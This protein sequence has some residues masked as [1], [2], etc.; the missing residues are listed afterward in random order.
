MAGR[1]CC[2]CCS[3]WYNVNV[4]KVK[5]KKLKKIPKSAGK[6]AKDRVEALLEDMSGSFEAFGEALVLTRESLSNDI[7][8]LGKEM[9]YKFETVFGELGK[10]NG[11][12]SEM[13]SRLD[14]IEAEIRFIKD[15]IVGLKSS[16]SRKADIERL[17][18]LEKKVFAM[19]KFLKVKL[20]MS[21]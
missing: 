14:K 16:L 1:G 21:E 2:G 12:M 4:K 5:I 8:N 13:N 3:V 7:K 17:D 11:E 18:Y 20:A 9:D 15:E 10:L 19:E 6:P